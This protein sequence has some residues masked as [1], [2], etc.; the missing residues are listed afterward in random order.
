MQGI[1][2]AFAEYSG[3][4]GEDR[5]LVAY[6]GIAGLFSVGA[7]LFMLAVKRGGHTLPERIALKD[8]LLL[9]V[10]TQRASTLLA[11]DTVTSALRA[12]FTEYVGPAGIGQID[13]TPRGTGA[14]HAIGELLTCPF[15][16]AQWV[17]SLFLS[18]LVFAPRVTRL[19][20]SA[21]AMVALSDVL[22]DVYLLLKNAVVK[23]SQKQ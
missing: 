9:G 4:T 22:Q 7:A 5:P 18:G 16:L 3:K 2:N 10:A 21:F 11:K 12:P 1:R 19:I 23:G 17:G 8:L 14:Q 6:S 20:A 15:C 13:E